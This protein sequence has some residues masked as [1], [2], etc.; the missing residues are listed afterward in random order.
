MGRITDES[1]ADYHA[2]VAISASKLRPF[3]RKPGGPQLYYQRYIAKTLRDEDSE[4]KSFGRALHCLALEGREVFEREFVIQPEGIDRRTKEGKAAYA[5]FLASADGKETLT[6]QALR[7]VEAMATN[8][9]AHPVAAQLLARGEP[10]ISW[11]VQA[12]GLPHCP[13]LQV[14]TDWINEEGCE[15]SQGRPY[16]L[17]IKTCATLEESAF[18]NWQ[19]GFE[20]HGYHRQAA[21]Y[22]AVLSLLGIEVRDFFFVP[23]EKCAPGGVKVCRLSYRALAQGQ[24]EV[25]RLLLDLD[26]CYARN[27]WPNASLELEEI[28]LSPWYYSRA[29]EQV[30]EVWS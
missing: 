5:A 27:W 3:A 21:F 18:G 24:D 7:E 10:E 15:L 30:A 23:A 9:H 1:S 8:I 26:K 20:E 11:R 25:S 28:D 12:T 4:A 17:D 2:T 29:K 14:R 13:P 16:I 22:M 6:A 19:R